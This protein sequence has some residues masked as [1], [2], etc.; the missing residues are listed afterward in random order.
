MF[1]FIKK[2]LNSKEHP[3]LQRN[4]N[5]KFGGKLLPIFGRGDTDNTFDMKRHKSSSGAQVIEIN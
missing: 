3:T 2:R 1:Q 4:T 5:H